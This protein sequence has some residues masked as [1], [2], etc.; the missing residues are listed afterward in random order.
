VG[1]FLA[2]AQSSQRALR[3]ACGNGSSSRLEIILI[4]N[5]QMQTAILPL[6]DVVPSIFSNKSDEGSFNQNI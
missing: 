1:E 5:T 6:I 2:N 4:L 3:K